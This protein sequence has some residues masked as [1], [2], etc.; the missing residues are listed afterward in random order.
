MEG[1]IL[2]PAGTIIFLLM[3]IIGFF[4]SR[5][6]NDVKQV[7]EETGKN[8]GR[9]DIV[10]RQQ[11]NDIKR[12]EERTALELSTLTKNVN[13]LSENVNTLCTILVE[14]GIKKR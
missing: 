14:N 9:I 5:V 8:K 13:A 1:N 2:I 7:M 4:V 3:G 11:E 6:L 12:I 10:A